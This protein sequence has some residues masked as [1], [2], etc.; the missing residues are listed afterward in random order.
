MAVIRANDRATKL[1]PSDRFTGQVW[2]DEVIVGAAPSRMRATNVS[3][4]PG[5]RTAWHSHPVGQTLYVISGVGR[6]QLEGETVQ[7]LRPGDTGVIPPNT[8]HWH[9]A[10]SDRLFVHLAMSETAADG[11]GTEWFELVNDTDYNATPA[12]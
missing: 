11:G 9:G 1:A 12:P 5:A 3:F 7:E 6:L 8:R 4:S 10:A 2:Q